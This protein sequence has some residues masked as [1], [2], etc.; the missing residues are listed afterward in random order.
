[1]NAI[2]MEDP[3]GASSPKRAHDINDAES[4]D[5]PPLSMPRRDDCNVGA[6]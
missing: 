4:L 6:N 2:V 3:V 5:I 1:M